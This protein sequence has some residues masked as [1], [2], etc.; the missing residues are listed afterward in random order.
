MR[1]SCILLLALLGNPTTADEPVIK[2]WGQV[3]DP[4]GDC[5]VG[6][7]GETLS[8][9]FGPGGHGLDAETKNRMNSP[10]VVRA[11]EDDFSIQVT[12]DGNLPLP[13]LD[14]V[15][16]RAYISGGL[17]LLQNEK[18][19]IRL[20]R[21]SFTRNGTIWHYTN[22]EQR[23]DAKR[24]RMGR[25]ADYPLQKDKPVQLR[26]EVS[27]ANV[28]ALVRHV[29][30]DWHDLGRAKIE[31][32]AELLA[33][34]SGVK[35][36]ADRATVSFRDL[37]VDEDPQPAEAKSESD[38]DLNAMRRFVQIP[39]P[40]SRTWKE[41]ISQVEQLQTRAKKVSD[42]S[43]QQ[44]TALIEDAKKLGTQKTP[45]LNAYL[46][47]SIA[48]RLAENFVEAGLPKQAVRVY[49]EFAAAL[50]QLRVASL[51][52]SIDSLRQAAKELEAD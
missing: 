33:G 21:A 49:R 42:L 35:T 30:D 9:E 12:V 23:I 41:L 28:R 26:L 22:F 19:Y 48:R 25:F 50:E 6:V 15:K 51:Q 5:K 46:G 11:L 27:G 31:D 20:E 2:D 7:D 45:K 44:Q 24:T 8:I 32:R 36:E 38:I 52:P 16:T 13:E 39:Q 1:Y 3:I 43:P 14:G 10:R 37:Q 17:V 29:G 4:D 34:V 18:N 47:P 40:A